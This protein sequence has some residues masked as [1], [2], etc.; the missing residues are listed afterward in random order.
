MKH[1]I[2]VVRVRESF[3]KDCLDVII[4]EEGD[5]GR[6]DTSYAAASE[7]LRIRIMNAGGIK[8]K[9]K[10]LLYVM[11]CYYLWIHIFKQIFSLYLMQLLTIE[12]E[13]YKYEKN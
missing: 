7:I 9:K 1:E 3:V 12:K 13:V 5:R 11:M 10:W 4:K 6:D 8:H 2:R